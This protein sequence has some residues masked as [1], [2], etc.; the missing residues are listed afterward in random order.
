MKKKTI[1]LALVAWTAVWTSACGINGP[2]EFGAE[3]GAGVG[4]QDSAAS[5]SVSSSSSTGSSTPTPPPPSC[6]NPPPSFDPTSLPPCPSHLCGGGA[7]CVPTDLVVSSGNADQADRLA[8]CDQPDT[9]CVPDD[10][11]ATQ[12]FFTAK[13]CTSLFNAEGRCLSTCVPEVKEQNDEVPLP[14]DICGDHQV[15]VPCYDPQTGEPTS[16]CDQGCDKGPVE[17]PVLLPACCGG[18]GKC[19]PTGAVPPAQLPNLGMYEC[20]DLAGDGYICAPNVF[21]DDLNYKP[22]PCSQIGILASL[23]LPEDKLEGRCLPDCLPKLDNSPVS[24]GDCQAGFMCTPC[25]EPQF[26]GGPK[27]TGA[28]DYD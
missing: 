12:G 15:C 5:S 11:I 9:L 6:D 16:A 22:Q 23:L 26:L 24:Q 13:T 27:P 7:R 10:Y 20:D 21:I 3:N 1:G 17:P 2:D 25:W 8:P 28:C 19:V 18:I 14:R 4:G